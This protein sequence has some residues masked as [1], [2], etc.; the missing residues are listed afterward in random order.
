MS[1][2][3]STSRAT[4][5][6]FKSDF[7]LPISLLISPFRRVCWA[8]NR[9]CASETYLPTAK[10]VPKVKVPTESQ[11]SKVGRRLGG[12]TGVVEGVGVTG[13]TVEGET[14]NG[15]EAVENLFWIKRRITTDQFSIN[16][17]F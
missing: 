2:L 7:M 8:S 13:G 16:V 11:C 3:R 1:D 9:F 5:S 12:A 15:T 10:I 14:S 6:D 4:I 17:F